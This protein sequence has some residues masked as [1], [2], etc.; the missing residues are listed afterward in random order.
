MGS[1][2]TRAVRYQ[3]IVAL[4]FII[5]FVILP[6]VA[7]TLLGDEFKNTA[8]VL[9]IMALMLVPSTISITMGRVL[10]ASG[11]QKRV[12]VAT[13]LA[14]VVNAALNLALIPRYGYMGAAAAAMASEVAVAGV[15]VLYVQ[16]Y[17]A[18]TRITRAIA[19]PILAAV[20]AGVAIY[21][22]PWLHLYIALPLTAVL[23]AIG[24]L[25][26][27]AFPRSELGQA[28]ALV[29]QGLARLGGS[30]VEAAGSSDLH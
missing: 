20:T 9:P 8:A 1:L 2:V 23:Y 16:R 13:G 18:R 26:L 30:D 29:R 17:V 10:V 6:R 27:R 14:L 3:I 21:Y 22:M 28:W 19:R 25:V 11:N 24:L 15:N 5:C 4:Y 7:P 12:M